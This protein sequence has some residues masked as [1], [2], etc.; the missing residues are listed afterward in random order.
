MSAKSPV[1]SLSYIET[2]VLAISQSDVQELT[3]V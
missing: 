1:C 2:K 3:G